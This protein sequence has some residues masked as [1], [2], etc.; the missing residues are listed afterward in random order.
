MRRAHTTLLLSSL[1]LFGC[2][3]TIDGAG[4]GAPAGSAG[5]GSGTGAAGASSSAGGPSQE[6]CV[7][8]AKPLSQRVVRLSYAQYENGIR[9]LLGSTALDGVS[10]EDPRRREFQALFA[11]G[12]LV[13]TQVLQKSVALGETAA[14]TVGTKYATLTGCSSTTDETCANAFLLR[15]AEQA[16]RRPLLADEKTSV[17]QLYTEAKA[18]QGTVQDAV[19]SAVLGVLIAPQAMYRTELGAAGSD[20]KLAQLTGYEVASALSYFL[21]D[22]PPDAGLLSA[23]AANQLASEADIGTQVDRLLALDSVKENL[24]AVMVAYY[25]LKDLDGTTKD[26]QVYPDFSVGVRNSMYTETQM[27]IEDTLWHGKISDL[28]TSRKTFINDTLAKFYGVTYPAA[29][30]TAFVPFEF[31]AGQRSGVVTH[32]SVM[33]TRARTDTTSVV[34]RGLFINGLLLCSQSPPPPPAAVQAKVDE[35]L[36]D[37]NATERDK[38]TFRD[39]TTPCNGCHR[40]FDGFG[41]VLENYDGIGKLRTSYSNGKPIDTSG[42]LPASA[43]GGTVPDATAFMAQIAG[44]GAFSRCLTSNLMKYALSDVSLVDVRDC[45]VQKTHDVFQAGDRSFPS[46][47]KQIASQRLLATRTIESNP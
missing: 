21:L 11:E 23:A 44:N 32:G 41:L 18:L 14:G 1:A 12:D 30:G 24:T 25:G 47:V 34:S 15:F 17:A 45:N 31:P 13:N 4:Y 35:Q 9:G 5:A 29:T 33:A 6:D 46:L 22:G 26:A 20:P 10:V 27:F 40:N 28:L 42:D 43:G 16:Y 37:K 2:T 38:A 3:S 19:R 8:P 7:A 36:N 39:T